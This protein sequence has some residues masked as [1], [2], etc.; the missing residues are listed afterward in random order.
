MIKRFLPAFLAFVFIFTSVP[1]MAQLEGHD[2]APGDSCADLPAGATRVNASPE[3]DGT[4]ILLICDGSVWQSAEAVDNLGD[5]TATK[6]L[7]LSGNNLVNGGSVQIANDSDSCTSG[8]DGAIRYVSGGDPPW[9]FCDGGATTW[10][11]F[12]QPRCE[13]DD[14]GECYLDADRDNDDPDF[15]AANIAYGVTILGVTGTY[16]GVGDTVPDA[17]SFNDVTDADL[18]TLI[19]SNGIMV[20]GIDA[21]T[22]VSVSGEGNA[23]IRIDG[24]SWVTS[25]HI[26]AGQTLEVRLTSS[27]SFGTALAAIVDIGGVTDEWNVIT[28]PQDTEPD[29]FAFADMADQEASTQITS[30]TVTINGINT[31][32]DISVSGDG[33][34]EYRIDSGPWTSADGTIE[35][36]QTLE[37]RLTSDA[38]AGAMS[39][40]TITVGEL[41]DQWDVTTIDVDTVPDTFTFADV[42]DRVVDT[43]VIS[44]SV[45]ITG[46]DAPANISITGAGS[47]EYRI[48]GGSWTSA[49]DTIANGQTL[50]LRLTSSASNVTLHSATVTIG[51]ISDQWNVTTISAG[52]DCTDNFVSWKGPSQNH[53]YQALSTIYGGTAGDM[54]TVPHGATHTVTSASPDYSGSLTF[55]CDDGTIVNGSKSCTYS[56]NGHWDF[57]SSCSSGCPGSCGSI[58]LWDGCNNVGGKCRTSTKILS[59]W[60]TMKCKS[61]ES[62][63]DPD[64]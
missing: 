45:A 43:L 28:V 55:T 7:N 29:A 37:I 4:E 35:D 22:G 1:A 10:L 24:G 18:D 5:H 32:V 47:P 2:S 50:E 60:M 57:D 17:F 34:P 54:V 19:L 12:K 36:G 49:D 41:S 27:A 63:F 31:V 11:P 9:E 38:T 44:N 16:S 58:T 15:I 30:N 33:N 13:D 26:E 46:I 3:Q 62:P 56:F 48:D 64:L 39:S 51:G 53:C 42:T 52:S 61:G 6:D 8:K 21:P 25:G 40:A 59:S 23:E 14:T 20:G